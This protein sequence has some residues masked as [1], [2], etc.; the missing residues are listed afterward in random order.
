M[1]DTGLSEGVL[2]L[3]VRK[4]IKSIV[5]PVHR[6]FGKRL[7]HGNV[8]EKITFSS[9]YRVARRRILAVG[10][11]CLCPVTEAAVS[12]VAN[13]IEHP[14]NLGVRST[15]LGIRQLCA[16]CLTYTDNEPRLRTFFGELLTW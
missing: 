9:T 2:P 5:L 8:C 4:V 15:A 7:L 13:L 16:M 12:E 11:V 1:N 3:R 14:A 10:L 6:S